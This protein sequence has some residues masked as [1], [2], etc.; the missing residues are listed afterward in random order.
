[1]PAEPNS[2]QN[3]FLIAMPQLMDPNFSGALTY[4]CE[5]NEH[6]A[7][8]IIVNKPSGLALK[9]VMEQLEIPCHSDSDIIYAGGPV[10]IDRGFI[11][12]DGQQVWESTLKVADNLYLTTSQDILHAIG[13]GEGPEQYLVALG[14]AGWGAGQLEDELKDNAWLTCQAAPKVLFETPDKDKLRAAMASLGIDPDQ[15]SRQTGHA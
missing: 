13:S 12:H 11:L 9:E 5:H 14:Y 8:G 2:L 6:G 3:S 15:L 10:Q 1:M 4:I 7:M